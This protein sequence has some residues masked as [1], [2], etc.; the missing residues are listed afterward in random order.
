MIIYY[1]NEYLQLYSSYRN[2]KKMSFN[3]S[4]EYKKISFISYFKNPKQSLCLI[5]QNNLTIIFANI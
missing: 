4:K 1:Q 3:I 5:S 2:R